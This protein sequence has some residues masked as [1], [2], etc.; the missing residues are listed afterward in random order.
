MT[1]PGPP[2]IYPPMRTVFG[3]T[4]GAQHPVGCIVL[5]QWLSARVRAS[6][7]TL[8]ASI[9]AF[10]SGGYLLP[11]SCSNFL[12]FLISKNFL[13]FSLSPDFCLFSVCLSGILRC[14]VV[15]CYNFPLLGVGVTCACRAVEHPW[16]WRAK[17]QMEEGE[18]GFPDGT[19]GGA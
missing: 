12:E 8:H 6:H 5:G 7:P 10:E 14:E 17:K 19:E 1:T 3:E 11:R 16:K 9:V 2:L 13:E 4:A 18:S 15:A